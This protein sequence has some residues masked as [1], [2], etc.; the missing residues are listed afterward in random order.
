MVLGKCAHRYMLVKAYAWIYDT[1]FMC[2]LIHTYICIYT[3]TYAKSTMH[4]LMAWGK[5]INRCMCTKDVCMNDCG[6]S[7]LTERASQLASWKISWQRFRCMCNLPF[8][9]M[10]MNVVPPKLDAY[11]HTCISDTNMWNTHYSSC[12]YCRYYYHLH[13]QAFDAAGTESY[14]RWWA[15]HSRELGF[16][17]WSNLLSWP[18]C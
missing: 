15:R 17:Q 5:Y 7:N 3:H 4:V 6:P 8:V 14:P 16:D 1:C 12:F 9:C 18:P 2:T 11:I 10:H 13:L